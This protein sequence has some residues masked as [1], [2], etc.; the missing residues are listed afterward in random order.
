MGEV[1][2]GCE[3]I[4]ESVLLDLEA[5]E[6][7]SFDDPDEVSDV[8]VVLESEL[9]EEESDELS[10]DLEVVAPAVDDPLVPPER[11]SVL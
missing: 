10:V 9:P 4:Q 2:F 3:P 6:V 1:G 11:E 5:A 8:L 7:V